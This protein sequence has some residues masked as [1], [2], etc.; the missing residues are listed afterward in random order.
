MKK[1]IPQ[2]PIDVVI[3]W[4]DGNDPDWQMLKDQYKGIK[5]ADKSESRYRDW[6]NLQY[7]FRG[8]EKYW[9]WVNRVFLITCGQKPQWL[10]TNSEKLKLV[11]HTDYI[12]KEYLPTFSSHTIE[13]NLHRIE[14]LS[15]HFIYMNDDFYP[16]RPLKSIDFFRHGLPCDDATQQTLLSIYVP[17]DRAIQYIDFTNLGLLN[18]HFRKRNVTKGNFFRWYGPYLGFHGMIQAI[19]KAHLNFF[20]GFFMHHT[21][22]PFLKNSFRTVWE[23][24]PEYLHSH[25]LNKFRQNTDVS[26][27]LIRYWQLA[28]NKFYP[29][30]YKRRKFFNIEMGN[31]KDIQSYIINQRYDI[32]TINDSPYLSNDDFMV[33]KPMVNQALD[34]ILPNKSAFEI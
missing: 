20:T 11:N 15:E 31:C 3:P 18:A 23:Y 19:T 14:E 8:I 25:C 21:P 2:Y 10:N 30:N 13:L 22:Q 28:E 32:I 17:N 26:Q 24:Y 12:P 5:S 33:V 34:S 4:V 1:N 9:P 6:D 16:I 29:Y 27:W 7:V